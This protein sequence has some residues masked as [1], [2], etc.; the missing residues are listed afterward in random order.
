MLPP[1]EIVAFSGFRQNYFTLW[2][3][4][5]FFLE[6]IGQDNKAITNDKTEKPKDVSS[7]LYPDFP[8]VVSIHQFR[9]IL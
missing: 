4:L 8:D 3:F 9:E 2:R 6:T 1:A 7:E 5:C